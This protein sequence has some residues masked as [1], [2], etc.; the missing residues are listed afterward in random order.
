MGSALLEGLG[1]KYEVLGTYYSRARNNLVRLDNSDPSQVK[2]LFDN[3]KPDFI[4]DCSGITRPDV[5]EKNKKRAHEVNVQGVKNIVNNSQGKI[6]YFSTDYVFNGEKVGY[7]ETDKTSPINYYGRTKK[8]A[9]LLVLRNQQNTVIR[10]SGLYGVNDSNNEFIDTY[11]AGTV[12][13]ASDMY[14][15]NLYIWDIVTNI[16]FFI[17]NNGLYHFSDNHRISRFDFSNMVASYLE[18]PTKIYAKP[19]IEINSTVKRPM[20]S[21]LFSERQHLQVTQLPQGLSQMKK[22]LVERGGYKAHG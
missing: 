3:L 7:V 15:C 21:S 18:L 10:V 1:T 2:K 11:K 8:E 19:M 9:E 12:Y 17:R 20:D 6:I 4:L 5:C 22:M 13:K 14:N 16:E